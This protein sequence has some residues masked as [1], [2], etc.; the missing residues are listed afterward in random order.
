MFIRGR[1]VSKVV[2]VC[3]GSL[4]RSWDSVGVRVVYGAVGVG[5][6]G[7]GGFWVVGILK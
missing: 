2:C 4:G 7:V 5:G 6:A 3:Y 1:D